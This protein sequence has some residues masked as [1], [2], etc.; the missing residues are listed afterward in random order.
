MQL[1][2]ICD[3]CR[4]EERQFFIGKIIELAR[5]I[6]DMPVTYEQDGKGLK[7]I[8]HLHYFKNGAHWYILEKDE[9]TEQYQTF[10]WA[11][12]FP[13]CGEFGYISI[14]ELRENE[15]ELD[16]H[17]LPMTIGEVLKKRE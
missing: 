6:N 15:I 13:G 17:F 3:G 2:A 1:E 7:A 4:S 9:E 11:E 8:A 16:L 12:L 5:I 10:G 14:P